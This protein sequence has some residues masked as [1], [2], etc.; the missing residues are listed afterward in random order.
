MTPL[1][2][3]FFKLFFDLFFSR[4][5]LISQIAVLEKENEIL[6]RK[7][8]AMQSLIGRLWRAKAAQAVLLDKIY[9]T[10]EKVWRGQKVLAFL[11]IFQKN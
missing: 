8:G 6:K 11:G 1:I 3:L 10:P 5:H 4:K 2:G 7:L 9:L